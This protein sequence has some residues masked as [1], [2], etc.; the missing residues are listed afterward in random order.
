MDDLVNNLREF[1]DDGYPELSIEAAD[2]IEA[3]TEQRDAAR[4]DAVEA[5][6]YATELEAKLAEAIECNEEFSVDNQHLKMRAQ[7]AEARVAKA[8]AALHQMLDDPEYWSPYARTTLA[9]IGSDK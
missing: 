4:H 6:A 1:A 3:L 5:E 9:E 7:K 2:R 8:V